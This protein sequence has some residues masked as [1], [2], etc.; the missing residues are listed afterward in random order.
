MA[1]TAFRDE[2]RWLSNMAECEIKYGDLV[3]MFLV[4]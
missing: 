1:I 2:H 3:L 4:S